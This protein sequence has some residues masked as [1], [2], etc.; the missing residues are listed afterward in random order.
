M[1]VLAYEKF[2]PMMVKV[3]DSQSFPTDVQTVVIE[4][5]MTMSK[6]VETKIR[7]ATP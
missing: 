4:C 2:I 1:G 7:V 6:N 5:V 3:V